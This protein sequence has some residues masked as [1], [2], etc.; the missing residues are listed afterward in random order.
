MIATIKMEKEMNKDIPKKIATQLIGFAGK[1]RVGKDMLGSHLCGFGYRRYSMA[2]PL[3]ELVSNMCE[4]PIEILEHDHLKSQ[5]FSQPLLLGKEGAQGFMKNIAYAFSGNEKEK[6][7]KICDKIARHTVNSWRELL[8]FIGTDIVRNIMCP[9][10]W[11]DIGRARIEGMLTQS[12]VVITDVRFEN[13][14]I[15][16]KELGGNVIEVIRETGEKDDHSSEDIDFNC[17]FILIN[18]GTKTD[19]FNRIEDIIEELN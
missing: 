16:I 17:D 18:E 8:Q 6:V 12:D 13:E 19:A 11:I 9:T 15:L 14:V 2:A 10:F 3:R 5:K 7:N 4:V 1:K